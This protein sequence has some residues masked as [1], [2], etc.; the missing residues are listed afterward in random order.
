MISFSQAQL[1]F[2]IRYYWWALSEFEREIDEC[3]PNLRLFNTGSA[4]S[5][6]QFITGMDKNQQ[7]A[8]ARSLLRRFHS[9]AVKALGELSC[10]EGDRLR[11]RLDAFRSRATSDVELKVQTRRSAGERIKFVSKRKLVELMAREFKNAFG[12]PIVE[13]GRVV[14]GDPRL[15]LRVRSTGG[16]LISTHF[17]FGR[18]ESLLQYDHAIVS[19]KIFEHHGPKGPYMGNLVIRPLMS[20]CDWLG[21]C[22]QTQWEYLTTD[23]EAQ[24][25]CDASI[26]LIRHFFE[27]APKLLKGLEVSS[28]TDP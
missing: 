12:D 16:W 22:S 7:L 11:D 26:K 9:D 3:F 1:D 28:I 23:E 6:Y 14:I 10:I 8:L 20:F 25:A 17:W 21:I 5:L 19:E 13:S 15:E 2:K 24:K 18:G 27:V 4:C